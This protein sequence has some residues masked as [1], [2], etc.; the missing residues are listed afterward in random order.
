MKQPKNKFLAILLYFA[1]YV[2]AVLCI[3]LYAVGVWLFRDIA[4]NGMQTEQPFLSTLLTYLPLTVALILIAISVSKHVRSVWDLSVIG[5]EPTEKK[6]VSFLIVAIVALCVAVSVGFAG[7]F[8]YL[9]KKQ[10]GGSTSYY[11]T[12]TGFMGIGETKTVLSKSSDME[13]D[14]S[15]YTI[16]LSNGKEYKVKKN[17]KAGAIA[18]EIFFD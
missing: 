5:I 1:P 4:S 10:V 8:S 16:K 13:F 6:K 9:S 7:S 18:T 2:S 17:T 3:V 11:V 15:T 14:G 12:E